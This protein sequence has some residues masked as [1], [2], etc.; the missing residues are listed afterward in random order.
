VPG[1][2]HC[3]KAVEDITSDIDSAIGGSGISFKA[4][5]LKQGFAGFRPQPEKVAEALK[6]YKK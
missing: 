3:A 1:I 2:L 6:G 5:D 4:L